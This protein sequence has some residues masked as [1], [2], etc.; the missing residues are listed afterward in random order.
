MSQDIIVDTLTHDEKDFF[1]SNSYFIDE[2][3]NLFK[4]E[5]A[6]KIYNDTGENIGAITQR[7]SV[8]EKILRLVVNK[9]I[10]P[11]QLDI[12]NH[13]GDVQTT[14]QRGWTFWLSK[15]E[16]LNSTGKLIGVIKKKFKIFNPEFEI[17][18]SSGVL[19][20]T[21]K[22]N[23]HAWD[24]EIKDTSNKVIASINKKWNGLAKEIF[25]SADKYNVRIDP[26]FSASVEQKQAVVSCAITI[27]MVL[28]ES[29]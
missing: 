7:L 9:K 29:K 13:E 18:N 23:F 2:K 19:I 1:Q 27:D 3:L 6:Y 28:K 5:N 22:G 21:V 10:L 8:G 20:A 26:A 16:V 11:F 25:T 4:F 24:F 14:I 15:I 12:H 17:Y